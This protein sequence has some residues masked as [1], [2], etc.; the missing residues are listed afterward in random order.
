MT[1]IGI[2]GHRYFHNPT[3]RGFVA[4]QCDG[5]LVDTQSRFPDL[6]AISMLAEGADTIFAQAALDLC[7]PLEIIRPF[8]TYSSDFDTPGARE[9]YL[10]IRGMALN[11]TRLSFEDRSL[12]AYE[13][14]MK[15]VVARS[16]LLVAAWDGQPPQGPGGTGHA[17]QHAVEINKPW[18]HLDTIHLA[19]I[20]HL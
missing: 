13:S 15:L 4:E 18:I 14:A 5:I 9:R 6:T 7:I 17:V 11:E 3:I 8:R 10:R 2:V 12:E 1:K 19:V 16:D 20:H